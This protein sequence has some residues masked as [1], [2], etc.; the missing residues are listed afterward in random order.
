[1]KPTWQTADGSVQ[2][3]LGDCLE[4]LPT[5]EAGSVDAVVTDPPYGVR[6]EDWDAMDSYEFARFSMAWL[7]QSRRISETLVS[8]YASGTEFAAWCE[9]LYPRVRQLIWHKPLGSQ[10]A[11]A[12]ES[13]MWFAYEPIAHCFTK[14]EVVKPKDLAVANII[15]HA[16]EANGLSRGG[17]DLVIRGKKTGLCYRWEEAACLPTPEQSTALKKL[18]GMNGEF[19]AAMV[20]ATAAKDDTLQK[21][22][23]KTSGTAAAKLDVF[24]YRTITGGCHP[25]EKPVELLADLIET[26][27]NHG[28]SILDPFMGSGTTGVACARIGRPFIGIESHPKHFATAVKRIEAELSRAPLF[29]PKP[30]IQKSFTES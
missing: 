3:Y 9:Y 16:R 29:E 21:M 2:L 15:K 20:A 25:C 27:T 5:I 7:S 4:V 18:L 23:D 12:S 26:T 22:S 11:G 14:K 19:D 6:D 30:V 28:E 17:V 1:M 10:Y 13:R 24:T 8:F